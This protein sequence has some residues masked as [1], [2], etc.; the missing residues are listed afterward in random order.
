M[1]IGSITV[2]RAKDEAGNF[3]TCIVDVAAPAAGN[4]PLVPQSL[5]EAALVSVN[6][7]TATATPDALVTAEMECGAV[8]SMAAAAAAAAGAAAGGCGS[9]VVP[10][11]LL[12][13]LLP[14]HVIVDLGG[15]IVQVRS[16]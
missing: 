9:P 12:M 2:T 3:Y 6:T 1:G 8:Q 15:R 10:S 14:F 16:Q 4:C 13:Q 7:T 11:A 5:P